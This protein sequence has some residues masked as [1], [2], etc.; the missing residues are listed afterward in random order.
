[1][2]INQFTQYCSEL[3]HT[4]RNIYEDEVN[5]EQTNLHEKK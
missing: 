1:M 3:N 5:Q 4:M 2:C